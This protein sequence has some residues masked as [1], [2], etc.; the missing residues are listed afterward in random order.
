MSP[1]SEPPTPF[2]DRLAR[3]VADRHTPVL[4]GLDPRYEKLPAGMEP[5]GTA[6]GARAD[7]VGKAVAYR[8]FC[9]AVIDVV[10]PLVAVVKPQAAFF[11]ELG[12]PGMTALKDVIDYARAKGLLVILDGKRNDIGTTAAAY[13]T[14]YLGSPALSAWAADALT[15]SPYLGGDSLDPFIDVAARRG[16]GIF[17]LVKTSNPGG[18]MFQ[19]LLVEGQPLYRHVANA[20][21]NWSLENQ[22]SCGYGAVGAVV[23]ATYPDELVALRAAMPHTWL[24]VPGYGSQGASARDV[25]GAFDERGLGAIIN[26]S[27]DII[28]A[29][30]CKEY[31]QRFG[32]ARWQEAVEAATRDMIARLRA[33]TSAGML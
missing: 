12:P 7:W 29:H 19:D 8:R 31:S 9:E 4:V 28:F 6:G 27:R 2:A 16:A 13:A 25:S 22:A 30:S 24:L 23:G 14:G 5:L 3:A 21:E 33:E 20:V 1:H 18:G 26:S 11:E 10:A 32:A 17:V 15:V